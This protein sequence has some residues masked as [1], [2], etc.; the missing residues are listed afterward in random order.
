[1]KRNDN[2]KKK[3]WRTGDTLKRHTGKTC[4]FIRYDWCG[5]DHRFPLQLKRFSIP[6]KNNSPRGRMAGATQHAQFLLSDWFSLTGI[7]NNKYK[8]YKTSNKK[9][10][11]HVNYFPRKIFGTFLCYLSCEE[12]RRFWGRDSHHAEIC[13]WVAKKKMRNSIEHM[14]FCVW[15][16]D[17]E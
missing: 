12:C 9:Q 13:V 8:K 3:E 14:S 2:N 7:K 16:V 17:L 5:I 6:C 1:M 15:I 10:A 11:V 4:N